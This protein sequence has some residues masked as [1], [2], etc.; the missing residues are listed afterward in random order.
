MQVEEQAGAGN[1]DVV[2]APY[3]AKVELALRKLTLHLG[4]SSDLAAEALAYFRLYKRKP[5]TH[6]DLQSYVALLTGEPRIW[7]SAALQDHMSTVI[8]QVRCPT[9]SDYV[10][11]VTGVH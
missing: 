11:K 1:A 2:R 8:N 7:L 4:S 9:S 10:F 5:M 6:L 3:L